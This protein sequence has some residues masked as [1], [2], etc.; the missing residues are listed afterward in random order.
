MLAR[1][2]SAND[3]ANELAARNLLTPAGLQKI[4]G[5]G[6]AIQ[7]NNAP[8][9][10]AALADLPVFAKDGTFV[11]LRD[12]ATVRDGKPPQQNIVHV[13]GS[14]AVRRSARGLQ[15]MCAIRSPRLSPWRGRGE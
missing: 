2:R 14:V 7:L 6:H 9:D 13:D 11:H 4:G 12:V 8:K 5:F 10:F 1:G 15:A 3:V